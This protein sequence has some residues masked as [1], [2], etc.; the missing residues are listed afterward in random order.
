MKNIVKACIFVVLLLVVTFCFVGCGSTEFGELRV[1]ND[2]LKWNK[3]ENANK[4]KIEYH[5]AESGTITQIAL[6]SQSQVLEFDLKSV[7][8]V[9]GNQTIVF[10]AIKEDGSVIGSTDY[11][12][13]KNSDGVISGKYINT[14]GKFQNWFANTFTNPYLA[15]FL[16]AILPIIELRGAI[17]FGY[18]YFMSQGFGLWEAFLMGVLG[19]S[20]VAVVVLLLAKPIMQWFKK[21]RIFRRFATFIENHFLKKSKKLEERAEEEVDKKEKIEIDPEV[22][23]K[24]IERRKL[25]SVFAFVA[26]P[27]P[28]TGVWTGSSL[29]TFMKIKR[30]YSIPT[31]LLGNLFAGLVVTL[32]SGFTGL[33]I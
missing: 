29:A 7:N 2:V 28:L 5:S 13:T 18:L 23:R 15:T 16:I 8:L 12:V 11:M 10:S 4:Y 27:L 32:I 17:P 6:I 24:K 21:T 19:S 1:E 20:A 25:I 9:S 22:R 33:F 26:V 31:V 3:I 30:R 14:V